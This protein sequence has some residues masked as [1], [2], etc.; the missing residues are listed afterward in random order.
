MELKDAIKAA[1]DVHRDEAKDLADTWKHLD[2]KAQSVNTVA[3][4]FLAAL[5]AWSKG[6][7]LSPCDKI[8]YVAA[9]VSL[10]AAVVT[11]ILAMRVKTVSTS[12]TSQQCFETL[13]LILQ[14]PEAEHKARATAFFSDFLSS[15]IPANA[16]AR[17]ALMDKGRLLLSGQIAIVVAIAFV[18]I[19]AVRRILEIS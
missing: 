10:L 7:K 11:A 16:E 1:V 3:G 19:M 5:F 17:A 15:S 2:G 9:L 8:F 18:A 4:V 14:R 6:D 12:A 13:Q